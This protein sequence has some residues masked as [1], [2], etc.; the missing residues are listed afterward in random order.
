MTIATKIRRS[1]G[2]MIVFG[3]PRSD[4]EVDLAIAGRL[5][6]EVLEILPY[7]SAF[8][9]PA[10]L[11]ARTDD[12]GLRIHSAHGCW[13]GQSIQA[14]RVDLGS[15]DLATWSSS[16]DDLKRCVDWLE[17]AGGSC[18]VVHPGGLSAPESL[19][20]RRDALIRGLSQLADHACG[21]GVTFCVENMPPGV[22]PGSRMSELFEIV[23]NVNRPEIA[24]ALD[25]GH[26][27]IS[28][29]EVS[30]TLAAGRRLLTTHV[31][32]NDGRQDVH[33]PPGQGSVDWAGW[34]KAL[35]EIDYRGPILLECIKHL[36]DKPESLTQDFL[37]RLRRMTGLD[38]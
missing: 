17:A 10:P 34:I 28:A 11:K 16:L 1:L 5:G 35:D 26:A 12:L 32:D 38:G 22:F 29:H 7:W 23:D 6:A 20:K 14:D 3:F 19:S 18:L 27:H 15:P 36:R 13:G 4:L 25:T 33:W 2:T 30:E 9:D 24:L 21:T 31:H 37:S 8:P